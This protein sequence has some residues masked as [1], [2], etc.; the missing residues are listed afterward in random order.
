M[1][2]YLRHVTL[3]GMF[4][5]GAGRWQGRDATQWRDIKVTFNKPNA[6]STSTALFA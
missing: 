6:N 2:S 5:K 3:F 4:A 1:F